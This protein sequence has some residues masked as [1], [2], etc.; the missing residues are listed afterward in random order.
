MRINSTGFTK[1]LKAGISP[2]FCHVVFSYL[3]KISDHKA[4]TSFTE[5]TGFIVT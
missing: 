3:M 4:E 5:R 1:V 2:G